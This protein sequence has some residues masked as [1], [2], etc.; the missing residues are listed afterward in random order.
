M[1]E[2]LRHIAKNTLSCTGGNFLSTY[3]FLIPGENSSDVEAS[4]NP[5]QPGFVRATCLFHQYN[6]LEETWAELGRA[7]QKFFSHD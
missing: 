4:R 1:E 5:T 6:H 3:M 7:K 2:R